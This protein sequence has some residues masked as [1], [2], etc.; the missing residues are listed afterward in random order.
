MNMV[1]EDRQGKK[2]KKDNGVK[3]LNKKKKT[4]GK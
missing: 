2:Q 3:G 1:A 4:M